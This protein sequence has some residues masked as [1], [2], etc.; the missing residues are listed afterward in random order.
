MMRS[1][2]STTHG[3]VKGHSGAK[4]QVEHGLVNGE[5]CSSGGSPG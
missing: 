5:P 4:P 3:L 1:Y 2:L